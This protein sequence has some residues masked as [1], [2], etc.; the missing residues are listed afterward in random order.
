MKMDSPLH[1]LAW[2]GFGIEGDIEVAVANERSVR[3]R[4]D[5]LMEVDAIGKSEQRLSHIRCRTNFK[6]RTDMYFAEFNAALTE[7]RNSVGRILKFDGKVTRIVVDAEMLAKARVAR[8][9]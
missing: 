9:V 4:F 2:R 6:G 1:R 3:P 8:S 5:H 7:A